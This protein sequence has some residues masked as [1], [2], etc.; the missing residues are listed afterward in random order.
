MSAAKK[1]SFMDHLGELRWS[2]LR[3]LAA[4]AAG[5]GISLGFAPGI[6]KLIVAPYGSRLLVI[7]PT[8]GIA[9]YLRIGVTAGAILAMPYIFF[10]LWGFISPALR[11]KEK[12][13]V[14]LFLPS[15]TILFLAGA[16]F[17]WFVLIPAAVGFLSGFTLGVFQNEWTTGNYIPF[18]TG[19]VFWVGVCFELPL[20]IFLLARMGFVTPGFL[21]R[22]WRSAVVL[23]LIVSAAV[24]PTVDPFNMMMVSLPM[25]GLYFLG[26]L[27]ARIAGR[28]RPR[29]NSIR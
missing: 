22:G 27:L 7:G 3:I 18:V 14:F 5:T 4:V 17:S 29:G 9:N 1:M 19:L 28:K 2:L 25:T 26:I 21:L 6:I 24:T 16:A 12:R 8:E 15:A 13:Y 20:A 10:E 23:I 11:P